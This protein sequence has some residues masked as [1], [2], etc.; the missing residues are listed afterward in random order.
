MPDDRLRAAR[1]EPANDRERVAKVLARC[2]EISDATS[3]TSKKQ[4]RQRLVP[5]VV[6]SAEVAEGDL[7]CVPSLSESRVDA[8][9]QKQSGE[10]QPQNGHGDV[11][12]ATN[13]V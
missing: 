6:P 1:A 8:R 7:E 5:R 2:L 12:V 9:P 11:V 10:L 13:G 4:Q 3:G